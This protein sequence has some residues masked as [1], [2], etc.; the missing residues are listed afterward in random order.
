MSFMVTC[1]EAT[2][3]VYPRE[4]LLVISGKAVYKDSKREIST[5]LTSQAITIPPVYYSRDL[6]IDCNDVVIA[7][8]KT[9]FYIM[10]AAPF[11]VGRVVIPRHWDNL[12]SSLPFRITPEGAV[13]YVSEAVLVKVL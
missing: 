4:D 8:G 11:I 3:W 13:L 9:E 6:E 1:E 12:I 10:P 7:F 5:R 2:L